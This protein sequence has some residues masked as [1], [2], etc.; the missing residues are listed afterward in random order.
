M[1]AYSTAEK[2]Q[3]TAAINLVAV[4]EWKIKRKVVEMGDAGNSNKQSYDA[5]GKHSR[6][7][8]S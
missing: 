1:T 6:S 5:R 2:V 4:M 3:K 8:R 7:C